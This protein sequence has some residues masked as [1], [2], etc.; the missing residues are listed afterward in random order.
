MQV[1]PEVLESRGQ[2]TRASILEAARKVFHR[3]SYHRAT[4]DDITRAAHV[5]HGTFYRYFSNKQA[6]LYGLVAEAVSTVQLP[7]RDWTTANPREAIREDIAAYLRA[8]YDNR[9]LSRIWAEAASYDEQI[10]DARRVLRQPF[11]ER[12]RSMIESSEK[13]PGTAG[14]RPGA[15][16]DDDGQVE[17][18][19][20]VAAEALA[21]MV[22]AFAHNRFVV[23]GR[24]GDFDS[25]ADTLAVLWCRGLGRPI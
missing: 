2:A 16:V 14:A 5:A 18:D 4:V 8:Y 7:E 6:A 25:L 17:I 1:R 23:E 21:C 20:D 3:K 10:A 11:L 12:I 13:L 15:T 19:V 24:G 9:D 22:E